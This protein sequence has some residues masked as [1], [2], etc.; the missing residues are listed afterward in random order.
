[1]TCQ[2]LSLLVVRVIAVGVGAQPGLNY[3]LIET[4]LLSVL[5]DKVKSLFLH[6]SCTK[7]EG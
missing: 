1:M 7:V 6:V 2:W 3:T 4:S 5:S